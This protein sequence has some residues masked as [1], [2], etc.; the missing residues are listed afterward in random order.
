M[1]HST[2]DESGILLVD[3]PSD[4][5]SHDVVNFIRGFGIK[6]VG[7]CGTLD[8]SA[9]GLLVIV[10]GKA[11]KL[12]GTLNT[13]EKSYLATLCLGIE[14]TT[15]DADGE[16]TSEKNWSH[17]NDPEIN[18]VFESFLGEQL[19]IPPMYSAKKV[20][21]KR[22]YELARKGITIERN[23][24]SIVIHELSITSISLPVVAF[25]VRCSKGTYIRTLSTD[26]GEKL[27]CGAHLHSLR[28]TGSGK[29][30]VFDAVSINELKSWNR[31]K[32]LS[33]CLP[34]PSLL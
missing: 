27:G 31:E 11:T 12:T 28:R 7:H 9:T 15:Q 18:D 16:I 32:L 4:W 34:A 25:S 33:Q 19:Q 23:P 3:K 2:N 22:L 21:G 1:K 26:I 24:I 8:P 13:E 14:T 20:K 17:V 10:I 5:T 30:N 29:F 6:K